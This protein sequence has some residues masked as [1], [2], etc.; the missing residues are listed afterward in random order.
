MNFQDANLIC[1]MKEY[2]SWTQ[3]IKNNLN[4][5]KKYNYVMMAFTS[6]V[7]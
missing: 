3:H 2:V 7:I 6:M 5:K 4:E 1:D